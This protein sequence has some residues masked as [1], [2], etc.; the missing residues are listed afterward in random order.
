LRKLE[1]RLSE[2]GIPCCIAL[3]TKTTHQPMPTIVST[4]SCAGLLL[5]ELF[6]EEDE[7]V[8]FGHDL[9]DEGE[10]LHLCES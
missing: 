9:L 5:T 10:K 2:L 4:S 1:R 8:D 3:P 6:A 7:R